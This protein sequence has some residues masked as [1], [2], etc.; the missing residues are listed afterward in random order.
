V[1]S[2]YAAGSVINPDNIVDIFSMTVCVN[3]APGF[4]N[5]SDVADG[6]S[7]LFVSIFGE[8]AGR[9]ARMAVGV[10]ELPMDAAVEIT[11]VFVVR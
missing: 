4:T 10:A 6:A 11:V 1:H 9:C 2:L 8:E 5:T 7:D 3:G